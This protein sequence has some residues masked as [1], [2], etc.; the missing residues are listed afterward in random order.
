MVKNVSFAGRLF[1]AGNTENLAK[2][3][4]R[5]VLML[6]NYA[7]RIESDVVVL[8]RTFNGRGEGKYKALLVGPNP[9]KSDIFDTTNLVQEKT[10]D[11]SDGPFV[12]HDKHNLI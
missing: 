4:P 10:F 6:Q 9:H 1:L 8:Q 2:A 11:F 3:Q 12:F 5:E 7:E